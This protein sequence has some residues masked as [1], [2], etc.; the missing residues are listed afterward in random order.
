MGQAG[1]MNGSGADLSGVTIGLTG[2]R[3]RAELAAALERLGA[4]VLC[5]PTVH[6]VPVDEDTELAAAL[7]RCVAAPLDEVVVTTG[8]GFTGWLAAAERQGLGAQLMSRLRAARIVTRGAK[9]RGAVRGAGLVDVWSAPSETAAE[10]LARLLNGDL[11]GHRIAVQ[12]HGGPQLEL[13]A[14]LRSA[15]ADVLEVPVYRWTDPPDTGPAR[16]LIARTVAGEV[17]ALAFTSAPAVSGMLRVAARAG[18][19]DALLAALCSST[20]VACVGPVTAAPLIERG[21]PVRQ[22]SRSRTGALVKL[23][24]AELST[25]AARGAAG[26]ETPPDGRMVRDFPHR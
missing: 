21:V 15:G 2:E 13:T 4:G 10:V 14:P 9:A 16:E 5:G 11:T 26:P 12:A 19:A 3:R 1:D 17:N 8:V 23:L 7:H 6:I 18:R 25:G 20:L 22:P 24:A